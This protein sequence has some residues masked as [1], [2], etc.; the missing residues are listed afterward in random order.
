MSNFFNQIKTT[1]ET[2]AER[3]EK[4]RRR[5]QSEIRK[6]ALIGIQKELDYA[7]KRCCS[8]NKS[9]RDK[10]INSCENASR[11][12]KSSVRV[13]LSNWDHGWAYRNPDILVDIL[14]HDENFK[15]FRF[16]YKHEDC[17]IIYGERV[18]KDKAHIIIYW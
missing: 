12:G 9:L 11:S 15:G 7:P 18:M 10:I 2:R 16:K 5:T 14:K 3:N 6:R 1:A 17:P 8:G 4:N 13:T